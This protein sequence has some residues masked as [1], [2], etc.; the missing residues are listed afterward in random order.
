MKAH[1][2]SKEGVD[3]VTLD[4]FGII[5]DFCMTNDF[6]LN[7]VQEDVLFDKLNDYLDDLAGSPDYSNYN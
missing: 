6:N 1:L 3:K 4:I 2:K 7:K 5:E